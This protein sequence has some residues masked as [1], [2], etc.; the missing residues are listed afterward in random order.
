M[1]KLSFEI[2]LRKKCFMIFINKVN[3]L[4][5][6]RYVSVRTAVNMFIFNQ[7]RDYEKLNLF[8]DSIIFY[9]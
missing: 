2:T 7:Q 4:G 8:I 6:N 9:N 1:V 3:I 5:N